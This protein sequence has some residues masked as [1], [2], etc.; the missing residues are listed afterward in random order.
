[1]TR[2]PVTP[3]LCAA[4]FTAALIDTD[5][6]VR[7]CCAYTGHHEPGTL[8]VTRLAPNGPRLGEILASDAWRE[9]RQQTAAGE[10]PPGCRTCVQREQDTGF[11]L[12]RDYEDPDW[13][14]GITFLEVN[15]SNICTLQCRACG[16]HFSH[17][18]SLATGGPIHKPAGS[19]L[20]RS[21]E[22]LD[23]SQLKR[24]AFKGGEPML[25]ADVF[26]VLEHLASIG[27]L[28]E[29]NV[30]FV[31]NAT[32]VHDELLE[33]LRRAKSCHIA[34]S[35]DGVGDVQTYI[36]HGNSATENID[37]FV[38]AF[39]R[40]EGIAF[41]ALPTV[42][43]Y[44]VFALDDIAQWWQQLAER[45]PAR[46]EPLQFYN[47][48][49]TPAHLSI[50]CL[51]D[52]TRHRLADRYEA[53]DPQLYARVVQTLRLPFA[54]AAT[55]DAFVRATLETDRMLGKSVFDAVPSL[56]EEMQLLDADAELARIRVLTLTGRHQAAE[57]ALEVMQRCAPDGPGV[58]VEGA[59]LLAARGEELLAMVACDTAARQLSADTSLESLTEL[60]IDLLTRLGRLDEAAADAEAWLQRTGGSAASL[61]ALAAVRRHQ[62]LLRETVELAASA[63]AAAGAD[64]GRGLA[65]LHQEVLALRALGAAD[66]D[67][68]HAELRASAERVLQRARTDYE[69]QANGRALDACIA[70]LPAAEQPLDVRLALPLWDLLTLLYVRSSAFSEAL[71]LLERALTI[72]PGHPDALVRKGVVLARAGRTE[73]ALTLAAELDR[74]HP[75]HAAQLNRA[76]A[77]L[78]PP[79]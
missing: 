52:A 5:K 54:G 32:I 38:Q 41:R 26:V 36:R 45:V 14:R 40:I 69:A 79:V 47:F 49:V 72:H 58:Q 75:E 6:G 48:V 55:H 22:S 30:S 19:L 35:L 74:L 4:P 78:V 15:T 20:Q 66:T 76:I 34:L 10:I 67:A 24:L 23:L 61:L 65:A 51:Q 70:V 77:E 12:R 13:D 57:L 27:R 25:N 73:T 64:P 3:P 29:V 53:L 37:C 33:L 7:P 31:S 21:L 56:A 43:V 71:E 1:M 68:R 39:S 63:R 62:G 46:F 16:S 18:W 59:R 60:R 28:A 42:M 11:A 8:G 17:R 50:T 9:I 44:N 2:S